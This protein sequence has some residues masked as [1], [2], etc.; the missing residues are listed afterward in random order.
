[1]PVFLNQE[2]MQVNE[3]GGAVELFS[4]SSDNKGESSFGA[5]PMVHKYNG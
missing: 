5:K 4:K 2:A 1:M 3:G